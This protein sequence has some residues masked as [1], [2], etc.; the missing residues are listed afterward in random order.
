MAHIS[1]DGTEV[2]HEKH[3]F[4]VR[5]TRRYAVQTGRT[6]VHDVVVEKS[7]R[8]LYGGF[9]KQS[10]NVYVDGTLIHTY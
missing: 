10:F 2:L 9:R 1:V 7:K 5:I 3:P 8:K 6:E 4:G